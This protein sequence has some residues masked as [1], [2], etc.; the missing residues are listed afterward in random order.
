MSIKVAIAK[1]LHKVLVRYLQKNNSYDDKIIPKKTLDPSF[2][3]HIGSTINA[4]G[5][6]HLEYWLDSFIA[7]GHQFLIVTRQIETYHLITKK[8]PKQNTSLV[9]NPAQ[10][11]TIYNKFKKIKAVF[12][13]ANTANNIHFLRT[14]GKKHIFIG[15]GDSDKSSSMNRL[16]KVYD[17]VFVSGQAHIDRFQHAD[18]NTESIKFKVIGRPTTE[19]YK[20]NEPYTA[21]KIIYIPTW[22]GFVSEQSYSSIN[23]AEKIIIELRKITDLPIEI[24][25]HPLTGLVNGDNKK[26]EQSIKNLKLA[27]IKIHKKDSQLK[28]LLK[29]NAVYICD[30][31]ATITECLPTHSPIITYTPPITTKT[32]SSNYKPELFTYTYKDVKELASAVSQALNND[33]KK[34][35]RILALDYFIN[36]KATLENSFYK[37]LDRLQSA[38]YDQH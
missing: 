24:K 35:S 13:P 15:H 38:S 27:N 7:S 19:I 28:T 1:K 36:K 30:I 16:F 26:I 34:D 21:N 2:I 10:I 9:T 25:L 23:L 37:N 22:E 5:I 12:Y 18:F 29:H 17:E 14:C 3:I 32:H 8:Y 6:M 31:S 4:G 11:D 33:Y 20:D